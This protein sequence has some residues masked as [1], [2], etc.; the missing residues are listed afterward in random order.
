ML[1]QVHIIGRLTKDVEIIGTSDEKQRA[2]FTVATKSGE[3]TNFIDC[4]QFS[5][6]D[7]IKD[8]FKKGVLVSVSGRLH[9]SVFT[10]KEEKRKVTNVTV[11]R[12]LLL[13]DT[14]KT[15]ALEAQEE[16]EELAFESSEDV[17]Y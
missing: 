7:F 10:D 13:N 12:S 16:Q 15:K 14:I 2:K 5:N 4:V 11:S 3:H 6:L 17:D 1:N 9:V 8:R